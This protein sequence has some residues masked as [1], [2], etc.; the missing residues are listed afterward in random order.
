MGVR[1]LESPRRAT[2]QSARPE[3]MGSTRR[4]A[5]LD[6]MWS[7]W[8]VGLGAAIALAAGFGLIS[9]WLTPRGPIT[10]YEAL[11]SIGAALGDWDWSR[12]GDGQSL[13]P[14]SRTGGTMR[15]QSFAPARC[16]GTGSHTGR[17]K[18]RLSP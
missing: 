16:V 3:S 4:R 15:T 1:Q 5:L 18:R 12:A 10:T 6:L 17:S 9:G 7:D 2:D 11:I 8:R 14:P 13:E